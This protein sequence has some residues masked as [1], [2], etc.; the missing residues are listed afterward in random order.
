MRSDLR[1]D[2]VL[3]FAKFGLALKS[4]G[5]MLA[6]LEHL[7]AEAATEELKRAIVGIGEDVRAGRSINETLGSMP[8]LFDGPVLGL[9]KAGEDTGTLDVVF[10]ALPEHL[11]AQGIREWAEE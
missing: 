4:G 3:F 1:D 5:R 10:R 6:A 8:H 7:K 2:V 9:V 11:L